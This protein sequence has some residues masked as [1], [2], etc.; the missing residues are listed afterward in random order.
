MASWCKRE[1]KKSMKRIIFF[2]IGWMSYYRGKTIVDQITGGGNYNNDEKDEQ[3]N[4]KKVNDYYY[5]Y[6]QPVTLGRDYDDATVNLQRIDRE[7][8]DNNSIPEVTVVWIATKPSGS[9]GTYIV[10]W[11]RN[12]TVYRCHQYEPNSN[13]GYYA[14][15]KSED[16]HLVKEQLRLFEIPRATKDNL[17]FVGQSNV[18]YADSRK[19]EVSR[20]VEKVEKY[21][22][23]GW[24]YDEAA[25]MKKRRKVMHEAKKRI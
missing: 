15:A 1:Q 6:V 22:E 16:C 2:N 12:A 9:R 8:E 25:L 21:I 11:Y 23:V 19:E 14:M 24:K 5:G 17:G 3:Y 10:G 4:F 18:W 7:W 20:L 13:H